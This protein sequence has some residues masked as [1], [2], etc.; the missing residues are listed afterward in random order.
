MAAAQ[1]AQT[2][3]EAVAAQLEAFLHPDTDPRQAR[4]REAIL[5]AAMQLFIAHGYRKTT[6]DE[7]AGTAGVAKGTVYLYYRNKAELFLHAIALQKRAYLE[8][9]APVFDPSLPAADR[10]RELVVLSVELSHRMPLLARFVNGDDEIQLA[11]REVDAGTLQDVTRTRLDFAASLLDEAAGG[12]WPREALERRAR[13]LM[14]LVFGFVHGG[15][16][17]GSGLSLGAEA[18]EVADVVVGGI[19][20]NPRPVSEVP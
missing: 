13:V 12:R 5:E 8:A 11:L 19:L 4:K 7:V 2:G 6:V 14:D 15:R 3:L 9:M 17:V 1:G 20:S 16:L 18:R 10:L